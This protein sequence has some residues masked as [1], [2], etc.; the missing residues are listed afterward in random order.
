MNDYRLHPQNGNWSQRWAALPLWLLGYH[1]PALE[2]SGW[3]E[4]MVFDVAGR[5]LFDSGNDADAL[6]L[7]GA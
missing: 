5:L 7:R 6:V 1:F 2:D 4:S 3:R